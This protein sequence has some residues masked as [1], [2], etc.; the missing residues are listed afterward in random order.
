MAQQASIT[1]FDG[2]A[3]PV[4]HVLSPVDNKTLP[5]GTR[6][7]IWREN[8]ATLPTAA[9]VRMEQRQRTLKSGVVETRTRVVVPVMESISGQNAAG[10]TAAPKVAF[11]DVH[12]D[13]SYAHPR[14]TPAS[15]NLAKQILRNLENNVSATT[16]AV[17]AGVVY[18]S[19]I[20]LFM[21]T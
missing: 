20:T 11:E 7:A 8:I 13:V 9:Q 1:V 12:E 14:S 17:A 6:V 16:P 3:T 10:Y 18:D 15:R 19:H 4:S 21:P 2:A 5:D